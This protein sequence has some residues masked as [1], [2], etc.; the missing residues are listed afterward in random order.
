M[1]ELI[2]IGGGGHA[3]SVLEVVRAD[4]RFQPIG[5][6]DPAMSPGSVLH[7]LEVLGN[8]EILAEYAS[9][10]RFAF[11][12]VGSVRATKRR[13]ELYDAALSHGF[14]FPILIHPSAS[15]APDTP[16]GAGTIA[17]PGAIVRI[18]SRIGTNVILNTGAIVD[19]H[20]IV[21][22]H[23]HLATNATLSGEVTVG[24]DA[25]IGAGATV[26]QGRTVGDDATVGGGA[27]VSRDVPAGAVVMGVP[28]HE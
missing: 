22:D 24:E 14:E 12:S 13:R 9:R 5:I 28:A 20:G 18:G 19:H 17:M 7:G 4:G 16:I 26:L 1:D 27:L 11:L 15:I 2:L 21:G 6:V 23:T 3:A 10:V 8:D 25:L